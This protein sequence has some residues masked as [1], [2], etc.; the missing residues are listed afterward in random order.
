MGYLF[1]ELPQL[2]DMRGHLA[3]KG[4]YGKRNTS[5]KNCL[6]GWHHSLTKKH[7]A[8]STAA[9]FANYHVNN[10]GWPG[11]GYHLIIEPQNIVDTPRGKRAKIVYAN[12]ITLKTY[13]V[14]NSN[15]FA[16]GICVAGDY[17]TDVLDDPTK[18]TID[19]LQEALNKD[20]IGKGDKSHNE[21]AGYSWKACCVFDYQ[22]VFKFLDHTPITEVPDVYEVQ[23][24]DTLYGLANGNDAFTVED[25]KRWNGIKDAT[26][27]QIG[28]KLY[29]KAPTEKPKTPV[30]VE[31]KIKW[32]GHVKVATLNV[33]KGAGTNY[34]VV[35]QLDKG[36]EVAVYEELKNGWLY[37]GDGQYASNVQGKY[38]AKGAAPF[39][40]A[41][42]RVEAIVA[43][44][45]FYNGPRWTNPSGVFTK[46]QGWVI[47]DL[48]TTD[49]SKQ[50]KVKNSAGK[51]FYITAR[52]DLV[53]VV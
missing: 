46:G 47:V 52:K 10:L 3:S 40:D 8:G 30:K 25:L 11:A 1:Q 21:F 15:D 49:G 4:S 22:K 34:P 31:P 50:Y 26:E 48:I 42:K 12:D 16:I 29:L 41:G 35:E 20:G 28:Q 36:Q 14:G 17:R 51:V 19:E 23:A 32:V 13:H 37:I 18:A 6:R 39:K 38:I 5:L 24:G 27:L 45:N 2:V 33:R 9:A 53:R 44:V 7:L 43:K